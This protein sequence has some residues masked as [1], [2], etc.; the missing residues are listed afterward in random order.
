MPGNTSAVVRDNA[1]HPQLQLRRPVERVITIGPSV[2]AH[3]RIFHYCLSKLSAQGWSG[4][5]PPRP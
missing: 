2:G 5:G 1:P 4:E 3:K